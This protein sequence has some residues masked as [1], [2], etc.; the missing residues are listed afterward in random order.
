MKHTPL[1]ESAESLSHFASAEN[2]HHYALTL[3]LAPCIIAGQEMGYFHHLW[4]VWKIIVFSK[5][6]RHK[7]EWLGPTV[8]F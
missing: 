3:G 4:N 1:S 6:K 7:K 5:E 2:S 8:H